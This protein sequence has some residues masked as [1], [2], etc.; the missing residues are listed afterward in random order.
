MVDP[1]LFRPEVG[2]CPSVIWRLPAG[3]PP[4]SEFLVAPE[5]DVVAMAPWVDAP[6]VAAAV[7]LAEQ[8]AAVTA[9]AAGCGGA[10]WVRML[11]SAS[12]V[13]ISVSVCVTVYGLPMGLLGGRMYGPVLSP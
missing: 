2:A 6:V 4:S 3:G 11:L 12:S 1:L 5:R 7:A 13:C 8:G 10:S 9:G